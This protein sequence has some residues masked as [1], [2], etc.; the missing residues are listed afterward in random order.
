MRSTADYA[1]DQRPRNFRE[2]IML[3]EP[4]NKAPLFALTSAMSSQS[5][6]DPEFDWWEEALDTHSYT[7]S[8]AAL[9]T[10][11]TTITV[12]QYA[13][14]LKPGDV[15]RFDDTGEAIRVS[16]ITSDTQFVVQRAFGTAGTAAGTAAAHDPAANNKLLY[17]GSAYREGAP[18]SVGVSWNPTKKS[19]LTQIFRDPVEWTRTQTKTRTRTGNEKNN[20]RRR[21]LNKHS[22]GIERALWLGTKLET[23]EAN[24]PLRMTDGIIN[25]IPNSNVVTATSAGAGGIDMDEFEATFA[26]IFAYGSGE[27]LAFGSISTMMV[28]NQIVRKNTTFQW[29]PNMKEYG[30]DVKRLYTPAGTIVLTEHPMFGQA[31]QF[32][33]DSLAIIDTENLK[34]RYIDDT[35]LIKDIQ[36][37]GDDGEAEEYLTECGLEV[38]HGQT[39]FLWKGITKAKVDD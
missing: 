33:A 13:N 3:L 28:I 4:R 25:F 26:T 1:A 12:T 38:H 34:Y 35:K 39:H 30:M 11:A 31:G 37:K 9:N 17:I 19:N 10:A 18:R 16:S 2:G 7:L 14:R 5:T 22:V 6:D 15:L 27:K 29:G 24:Q 8:G 21:V 20:D 36:N 23:L 32:L